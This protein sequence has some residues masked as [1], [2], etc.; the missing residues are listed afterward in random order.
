MQ[1]IIPVAIIVTACVP[2][3]MPPDED[4]GGGA[5][6][7]TA[8]HS[9]AAALVCVVSPIIM[10]IKSIPRLPPQSRG[11]A[12]SLFQPNPV[13]ASHG[14]VLLR[15]G[16]RP[17]L[18]YHWGQMVVIQT[19]CVGLFVIFFA[20]NELYAAE[21]LLHEHVISFASEFTLVTLLFFSFLIITRL[22]LEE[23]EGSVAHGT[24]ARAGSIGRGSGDRV[25]VTV[26][27]SNGG[28]RSAAARDEEEEAEQQ[29]GGNSGPQAERAHNGHG[30][31]EQPSQTGN[32]FAEWVRQFTNRVSIGE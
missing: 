25:A 27:D 4:G 11:C 23:E 15:C 3:I 7:M 1:V 12:T 22:G 21:P 2:E 31:Q 20:Y 13:L 18:R 10:T 30:T 32:G 9:G 26:R 24:G 5:W 16:G 29:G 14:D 8:V 17:L 6:I 28:G 19:V